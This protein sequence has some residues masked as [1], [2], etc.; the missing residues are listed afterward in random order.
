MG[1]RYGCNEPGQRGV[2]SVVS[3][4]WS[5][6]GLIP[7]LPNVTRMPTALLNLLWLAV[8]L[9]PDHARVAPPPPL[10]LLDSLC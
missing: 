10:R 2:S 6:G 3:A 4:A 7:P 8:P 1:R 9:K 5:T